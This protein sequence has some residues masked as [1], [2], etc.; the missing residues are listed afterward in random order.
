MG[1]NV[2]AE[3]SANAGADTCRKDMEV[4]AATGATWVR[5][6]LRWPMVEPS[7]K[8]AFVWTQPDR[9]YD[10]ATAAGLRVLWVVSRVPAWARTGTDQYSY[11]TNLQDFTDFCAAA[12]ARYSDRGH[13][14]PAFE[15]WNEPNLDI[16]VDD[17]NDLASFVQVIAAGYNG[18]KTGNPAATVVLGAPLRGGIEY[19]TRDEV[20]K[21]DTRWLD[22]LYGAGGGPGITHDVMGYHPYCYPF[23]PADTTPTGVD[24][25]PELLSNPRFESNASG[26]FPT[27]ATITRATG[28]RHSGDGA[29]LATGTGGGTLGLISS[30]TPGSAG[31]TFH[32]SCWVYAP[33]TA[34]EYSFLLY[35][36]NGSYSQIGAQV[37]DVFTTRV[38][39]WILVGARGEAPSG[40]VNVACGLSST[41]GPPS[42]ETL[43]IDDCTLR[44]S[45]SE[46]H[47]Y[48]RIE[49]FRQAMLAHGDT[50][51]IWLTEYGQHTADA[52]SVT[53]AEQA[54]YLVNAIE[55]TRDFRYVTALFL[56][57]LRN[58]GTADTRENRFGIVT[59]DWQ[60][61]PSWL[62]VLAAMGGPGIALP[63]A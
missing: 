7:T 26:W 46:R 9:A 18:V 23:D 36:L 8:G 14:S 38:G 51:P 55:R 16:H 54:H 30:S 1:W 27:R 60:P 28:T 49:P 45:S 56:F 32:A 53:E 48:N 21:L 11:P 62:P 42:G 15:L 29:G 57:N 39:D 44:R 61:R 59:Y 40:T 5:L 10:A 6:D 31:E 17:V 12:A 37:G 2:G 3:V 24:F 58:N 33:D 20:V 52:Y 47:G 22:Q 4:A 35:W 13:G 41:A 63:P 25:G 34:R 19:A 43:V 50:S